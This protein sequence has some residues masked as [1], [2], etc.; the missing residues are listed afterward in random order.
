MLIT[1]HAITGAVIGAEISNPYLVVLLALAS[2]FI[3]DALPHYDVGVAH[4]GEK[5]KISFNW[6]DW[7]LLIFDGILAVILIWIA[8]NGSHTDW[9]ILIGAAAGIAP[10]IIDDFLRVRFINGKLSFDFEKKIPLISQMHAFHEK[11][12]F[13]LKPKYWYWGVATQV[14]IVVGGIYLLR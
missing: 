3:L 2:H 8:Y 9:N 12:H 14:F 1:P 6:K 5:K 11:I 7:L 13:K 4:Y 10:D